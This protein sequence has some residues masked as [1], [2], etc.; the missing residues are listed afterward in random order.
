MEAK[1]LKGLPP[2]HG[3]QVVK[4]LLLTLD[5]VVKESTLPSLWRPCLKGL[6]LPTEA[7]VKRLLLTLDIVVKE[8]TPPYGG[9][10]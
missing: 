4:G 7:V 8:P 3:G 6:P 10:A 5:S 2:P 9:R 1:W